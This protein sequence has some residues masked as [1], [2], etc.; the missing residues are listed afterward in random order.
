M[1]TSKLLYCQKC[2]KE[3]E[4]FQEKDGTYEFSGGN[5]C[6]DCG[7]RLCDDCFGEDEMYC[8]KCKKERIKKD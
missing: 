2:G 7:I 8:M 5:C 3:F 6:Y 4:F 1:K